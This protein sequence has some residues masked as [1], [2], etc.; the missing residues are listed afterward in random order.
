MRCMLSAST[1]ATWW[2]SGKWS[3]E[4]VYAVTSLT[5][6]RARPDQLAAALRGHWA[7][8]DRLHWVRD[9][10]YGEDL[11]QVRTGSGPEYEGLTII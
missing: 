4:T 9:V 2:I 6:A 7:I 3:T 5:A 8:E 11:S 1:P 10:T